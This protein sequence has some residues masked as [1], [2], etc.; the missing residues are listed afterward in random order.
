VLGLGDLRLE[1]GRAVSELRPQPRKGL[2]MVATITAPARDTS[3][4][5]AVVVEAMLAA[6]AAAAAF[7][8]AG[9]GD[10]GITDSHQ[11]RFHLLL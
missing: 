3:C 10:C 5:C 2:V 7:G 11:Q 4:G 1:A 9:A 6:S 8:A